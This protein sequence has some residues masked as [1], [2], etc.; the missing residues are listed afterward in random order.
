M[1]DLL[2]FQAQLTADEKLIQ[3]T[4]KHFVDEEVL[5]IIAKQYEAGNFPKK[6]IHQLA[7]LGLFGMTLP[8]EYGGSNFGAVAYGIVCHEL[9]KGDSGLRS[10]I[11][12]QSSLCMF[13]IFTYGTEE[14][15]QKYLIKM[16]RGDLIG[17]FGLT[18]PDAGSD[19][20]SMQT[21]AT[22]TDGGWLINGSKMWI[23]NA[24]LADLAIVWA[25]TEDGIRGFIVDAGTEG[26]TANEIKHKAS[27]RA[28]NTGELVF[29]DCF[30]PDE[31]LLPGT[32]V[33]LSAALKCLTKARY[34]IAWGAMGSAEACFNIALEYAKQ[35]KQFSKPIAQ[36]QL[37]Q[38]DLTDMYTEIVKA[39]LLNLQLGRLQEQGIIDFNAVSLAKM[40]SCREAL[41]I[42]RKARNILGANGISLEYHVIRH[43]CNLETVF[44]YEGTDNIHHLIIG[45]YL[46]GLD[47]F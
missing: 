12:V 6:W 27:L 23:S 46:T 3:T 21:T 37:I 45:K 24:T 5:P 44:T 34:G 42:A 16:S 43:V 15:K 31:S 25:K 9:E 30:V 36:N 4:V 1:Q 32:S 40:N 38:K 7:K 28:S 47:G 19:P 11:S 18:E 17:C 2:H 41:N 8:E 33:G 13:P 14:Q 35:R 39:Q 26:F 10:F 29:T 20:G 22:K